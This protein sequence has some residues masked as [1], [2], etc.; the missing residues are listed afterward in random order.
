VQLARRVLAAAADAGEGGTA[1]AFEV[2]LQLWHEV[3]AAARS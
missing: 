3:K 1:G 2:L